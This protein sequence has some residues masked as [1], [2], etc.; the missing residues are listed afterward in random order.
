[1][2]IPF[3]M[4]HFRPDPYKDVNTISFPPTSFLGPCHASL[5]SGRFRVLQ[6]ND[7]LVTF[8]TYSLFRLFGSGLEDGHSTSCFVRIIDFVSVYSRFGITFLD[9]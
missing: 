2:Q 4:M 7:V 8:F 1:M 9:K 3:P 5:F 6:R